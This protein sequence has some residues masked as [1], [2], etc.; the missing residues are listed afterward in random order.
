MSRR[1]H[2][3]YYADYDYDV[4]CWECSDREGCRDYVS[5]WDAIGGRAKYVWGGCPNCSYWDDYFG[6]HNGH[7]PGEKCT[8]GDLW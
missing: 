7:E 6:C 8:D 3:C 5:E 2:D 1:K 4:P